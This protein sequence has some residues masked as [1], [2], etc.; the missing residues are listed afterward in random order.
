MLHTCKYM[1]CLSVHA[2]LAYLQV[3]LLLSLGEMEGALTKAI[4]SGDTDLVYLALFRSHTL[5]CLASLLS[6]ILSHNLT[7]APWS[8][9][10]S[11]ALIH[12]PILLVYLSKS[13][14]VH[15]EAV[16]S[17]SVILRAA[18]HASEARACFLESSAV[19]QTAKPCLAGQA[20][21]QVCL[22]RMRCL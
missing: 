21:H 18:G 2:S 17:M 13:H 19:W 22:G 12:L 1:H 11:Q 8:C 20:V 3:P 4:D 10:V 9:N 14:P 5:F 15:Q 16:C 7:G 6:C